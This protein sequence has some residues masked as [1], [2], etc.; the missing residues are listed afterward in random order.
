MRLPPMDMP[1]SPGWSDICLRLA[2]TM[3]AGAIIG[4][5]RGAR[6]H[7]AGFRTTILVCL[8]ASVAMIQANLLLPLSGK[9]PESFAVM[10]LMRLPLGILTGVG[11]IGG[12]AI[13]KKG[14]LVSG[15]T[16]AAT[17]WLVTVIGLCLGGG[18]LILGIATTALGVLTL[19]I[20]K[21]VD[22]AIPREH[23]ATMTVVADDG[24]RP[25]SE[26][27]GFVE[28]LDG[29]A[30]FVHRKPGAEPGQ[31]EYAFEVTWRRAERS[32]PPLDMLQKLSERYAITS[33]VLTT[34]NGR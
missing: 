24:W 2:L 8:A 15:V 3:L 1:L 27:P 30:R 6:G 21:W 19:W 13:L 32:T 34:E 26:L 14:D 33:F 12:G 9:T 10:D 28:A 23:R 7:A 29:R 25:V 22:L 20:L 5:N 11:F 16:T 4:F 31:S 18:Q 17:L